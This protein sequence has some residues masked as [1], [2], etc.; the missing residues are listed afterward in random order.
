MVVAG[1]VLSIPPWY[2]IIHLTL[3]T[4]SFPSSGCT[5]CSNGPNLFPTIS[6]QSHVDNAACLKDKK[7]KNAGGRRGKT[8]IKHPNI[9]EAPFKAVGNL[10][11]DDE[12]G[13]H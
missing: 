2:H 4:D 13:R 3:L 9:L 12:G 7:N 10:G 11:T 5:M 6:P 1:D 8:T